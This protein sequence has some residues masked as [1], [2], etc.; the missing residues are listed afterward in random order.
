MIDVQRFLEDENIEFW[1][2]GK[3]VADGFINVQCPHCD[4]HSNHLGFS[5]D[6]DVCMCWRCGK[7]DTYETLSLLVNKS[8]KE[9][10]YLLK[11]YKNIEE[12]E[13]KKTVYNNTTI[14]IPGDKLLQVHKNYLDNRGFDADY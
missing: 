13:Y 9:V 6:G 2:E 8:K 11:D 14:E 3:N 4:D 5:L 7:H 10:K 1:T 12:T